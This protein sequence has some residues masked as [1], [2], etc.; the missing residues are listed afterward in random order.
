MTGR[1]VTAGELGGGEITRDCD[2]A[3]IGSGAGGSV[4]AA[5]L[6][7]RGLRIVVLEAG[8]HKTRTDFD[9]NEGNAY[10]DLYQERGAR[11]TK[12]LAIT[13]LQGRNVGGGT[14]V[15]WTT[16]YRT[17][18]RILRHWAAVYGVVGWNEAALRPHWEAV[19]RRLG[20]Q[21]WPEAHVNGNNRVLLDGCRK[22]GWEVHS[23]R[24]NVRGCFDSGS[25]GLGCPT[26]AKQAM[27][28][29]YLL[30]AVHAGAEVIA[31]AQIE[32]IDAASNLVRELRGHVLDP[33]TDRPTR[34]ALTV[35][36]KVYVLAGGAINSPALLIRS[37]LDRNGRAGRRS[38]LHPVCVV[39]GVFD[40]PIE[41]WR[42]APQSVASHQWEDRGDRMGYFLETAP[43]HP[44]LAASVGSLFGP[45]QREFLGKAGHIASLIG[46][47]IDGLADEGGHVTVEDDGRIWLHYPVGDRLR[48]CFRDIHESL[49]RIQLAAGAREVHTLHA[50]P[51]VLRAE[52][53][54]GLLRDAPYGPHEHSLFS[55][56][57]MGGCAMGG[58]PDH[59]V[60][61]SDL[62]HH[63]V[64]NLYV[65]DGSVFPT[66]LGVNPS[67]SI[68]GF[69][70]RA[71]DIVAAAAR[72]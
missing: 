35:R 65:V 47:G 49:A 42:G 12:D 1:I 46:L 60:V 4:L 40:R 13:I 37:G 25:C 63:H 50:T 48:E 2:V 45:E 31:R 57:P 11:A 43:L 38:M 62:R 9:G 16:C 23:L 5:G 44:M 66:A 55:A 29:T 30:D 8:P 58:D 69:A 41:P 21:V 64:E 67:L 70:H 52:A 53:D 36:A 51:R 54:V 20:V 15:N 22:L 71:R 59:A 7:Q 27:A 56:H 10:A 24:R 33:I 18:G 14:T 68:Y 28:V 3:I 61:R 17:P 6:A 34:Q 19:E 39:A 72:T 32:S 26:G